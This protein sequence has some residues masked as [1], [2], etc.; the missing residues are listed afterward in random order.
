MFYNVQL[1]LKVQG[2]EKPHLGRRQST[3]YSIF[4]GYNGLKK[5]KKSESNIWE[6]SIRM[7]D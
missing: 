2:K 6:P 3:P 7:V 5:T 1:A 4:M